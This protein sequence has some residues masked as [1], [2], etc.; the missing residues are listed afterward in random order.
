MKTSKKYDRDLSRAHYMISSMVDYHEMISTWYE[1]L[2]RWNFTICKT[3]LINSF[4]PGQNG[5][6]FAGDIFK[7]NFV[8]LYFVFWFKFHWSLFQ[9]AQL[10]WISIGSGNGLAPNRRHAIIWTNADPVLR[11]RHAALGGNELKCITYDK[12]RYLVCIWI[13]HYGY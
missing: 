5:R 3:N 11:Q 10:K 9:R 13:K 2:Y 4:S 7:C 8:F 1:L 12:K 6:R